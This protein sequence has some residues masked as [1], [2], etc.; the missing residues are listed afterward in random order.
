MTIS[1]APRLPSAVILRP[2]VSDRFSGPAPIVIARAPAGHGKTVAM[3]QWASQTTTTGVWIRLRGEAVEPCAFVQLVAGELMTA[4]ALEETDPLRDVADALAGGAEPWELLRGGLRRIGA[5]GTPWDLAIDEIDRLDTSAQGALVEIVRDLAHVRLR[6]TARRPTIF[7]EPALATSVD[8]SVI[9]ASELVLTRTETAELLSADAAPELVEDVA[10]HGGVPLFAQLI[11]LA[12]VDREDATGIPGA[13]LPEVVDSFVRMQ[14]ASPDVDA[15]LLRFLTVTAAAET[16]DVALATRLLALADEAGIGDEAAPDLDAAALLDRAEAEG[17]GMWNPRAEQTPTFTYTPLVRDAFERRLRA[18]H[19]GILR[20]LTMV[21]AQWEFQAGRVFAAMRGA[22]EA[23]DWSFAS[24]VVRSSWNELLRNHGAEVRE[25]FRDAPLSLLRTQPLLTTLLAIDY[26]RTGRHR[27]RALEYFA[28]ARYGARTQRA[29]ASPAD[30]AVLRAVESAALRVS[31]QVSAALAPA[32]DGYETL[33]SLSPADRDELD[34][35]EPTIL[36]QLGTTFFYAGRSDLALD[37]FARST[38]VSEA[39]GLRGG[40][41]GLALSAGALAVAGDI[42]EA[43]ALISQ[44]HE[45]DWPEGWLQGYMGSFLQLAQ[46]MSALEEFDVDTADRHI[47]S[48]DPHRETIEHWPL[49][50]HADALISLLRGEVDR[51]R[52]ELDA[53]IRHQHRRRAAS[54]QTI[55]RLARTR[56]L[57]ELAAGNP[58]AADR[59]LERSR[60]R[61]TSVVLAR[62][63]LARQRPD[64]ALRRLLSAESRL[65]TGSGAQARDRSSRVEAEDLVLRA[66]AWALTGD[67]ARATEAVTVALGY[68]ANRQQGLA[69]ALLPGDALD[70]LL[71]VA[72]AADLDL[73][74]GEV[75]RVLP[76]SRHVSRFTPRELALIHALPRARSNSELA[77]ELSVS[78]NTVKTQLRGLYRKLGVG[79]RDEALAAL[80]ALGVMSPPRR[81]DEPIAP[82]PFS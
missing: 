29:T 1:G 16:L 9:S 4:G 76:S 72:A 66:A 21:V 52:F 28:L 6:A 31:G 59:A 7:E 10:A 34:R 27:L 11:A 35:A 81:Y 55:A 23:Q 15:A 25:L 80:A 58:V 74:P 77:A 18:E 60:A 65:G 64:E 79:T 51:A 68:L 69:L 14:L 50:A 44:A 30:R 47:R 45:L 22:A 32:R 54:A 26:N 13:T 37:A 8:V 49:L 73:A 56:S 62:I 53:E 67:T 43:R 61:R 24:R 2:R 17:L 3:A 71:G 70:A 57:I 41:Q 63:D 20:E 19:P 38:A 33:L 75:P 82:E 5:L 36:N 46:A 42:P 78:L 48:L 40:L 12:Q 39:R